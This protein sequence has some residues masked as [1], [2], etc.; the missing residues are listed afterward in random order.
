[1]TCY[2]V[3][4]GVVCVRG[5]RRKRCANCNNLG[6]LECDGCDKPLC[7]ECSVSPGK[8]P[9]AGL[10]DLDYCPACCRGIFKEWCAGEGASYRVPKPGI[11]ELTHK[12]LRRAAFRK[13]AKANP[14]K[15]QPLFKEPA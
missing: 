15:F 2:R 1:M 8:H 13:W 9:R 12:M 5:Q 14:E 6:S 4:F 7:A 10:G 11:T 3:P